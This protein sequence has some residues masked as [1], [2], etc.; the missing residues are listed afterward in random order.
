MTI[1]GHSTLY[2]TNNKIVDYA[3]EY[4][5][6]PSITGIPLE[7]G[8]GG[9][10]KHSHFEKAL[11]PNEV[12]NPMVARPL[13][14]SKFSILALEGFG[15]YRGKNADQ[16]YEYL[17]NDGCQSIMGNKCNNDSKE[18]CSAQEAGLDHCY[19]NMMFKG[20]CG[21]AGYFTPGCKYIAPKL[22]AVCTK[23]DSSNHKTF[24]WESYGAHSRCIT[25]Q[26]GDGRMNAACVRSRCSSTG[27]VEFKFGDEVFTCKKEGLN[28]VNL[29]AYKGKINC[30]SEEFFCGKIMAS[31]CPMDCSGHGYCMGN[32]TCQCITGYSGK[33]CNTCPTCKKETDKFVTDY[34]WNG[35]DGQP[36]PED[37][38]EEITASAEEKKRLE[39]SAIKAMKAMIKIEF[40]QKMKDIQKGAKLAE[41]KK[42]FY[43]KND[44]KWKTYQENVKKYQTEVDKQRHLEMNKHLERR[45]NTVNFRFKKDQKAYRMYLN[46]YAKEQDADKKKKFSH[47]TVRYKFIKDSDEYVL[48][49]LTEAKKECDEDCSKYR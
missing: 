16:F 15:W 8:G 46:L 47:L 2:L 3:K 1:N 40:N 9:G 28:D 23:P 44:Q 20:Q 39:L 25:A 27:Q 22:N 32:N 31:R 11:F 10:S 34:E 12:M 24:G 30:P 45:I 19:T 37:P 48:D 18:Y 49:Y 6:C 38:K 43:E 36:K 7:N 42:K 29:K 17:K 35:K 5:N 33:D 26:K 14:I 4:F 13:T 41:L 21:S